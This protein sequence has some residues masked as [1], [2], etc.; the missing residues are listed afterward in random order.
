MTPKEI[1]ELKKQM[2]KVFL[3]EWKKV[4]FKKIVEDVC[5]NIIK[6]EGMSWG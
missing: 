1:E 3:E 4:D 2:E 5:R 6:K